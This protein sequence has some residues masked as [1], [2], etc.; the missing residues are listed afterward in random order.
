MTTEKRIKQYEDLI[1]Q[2]TQG[3]A[4]LTEVDPEDRNDVRAILETLLAQNK[5]MLKKIKLGVA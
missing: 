3:L 5:E 2:E 1:A 4:R